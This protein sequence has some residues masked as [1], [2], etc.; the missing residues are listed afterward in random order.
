MAMRVFVTG[1]SG[2]LGAAIAARL[3]K[4]DCEVQGL[5]RSEER[6]E[7]VASLGVKPVI[8]DLE[9][10]ETFLSDLKNND[11]VVH[12]A[13]RSE[14]ETA[15]L[16][17]LALETIRAGVTD[18]RV[19]HVLYTS[20]VWVHGDTEGRTEDETATL[21]P[22]EY[23]TWRPA[24]EEAALD[25]VEQEAH[26]TVMRPGMVYGGIGGEF[27]HWFREARE[28]KLVTYPGDG[29]QHWSVVHLADVAEGYRLA[30]EHARGGSR[31][32]LVDESRFTVRELAEAV[33]RAAE[34]TAQPSDPAQLE[35]KRGAY[36]AA[37]LLDQR[38]TAAKA[39][40]EL[41]WVPRH[42]S[43]VNEAPDLYGD[44]RAGE[45]TAVA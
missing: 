31:Y 13:L 29:S 8:G 35:E 17:R 9:K 20:G 16:D 40:R 14:R 1:A 32:L 15:R 11:A 18:G 22:A 38:L 27:D 43:F 21:H 26:V 7:L 41:G 39:R 10:P 42:T 12:A 45:R 24:H 25:M 6:A 33:A 19:R 36:G 34:A 5:V 28:R 3:V 4:G 2:Y 44:W 23:S 37:L 30:L